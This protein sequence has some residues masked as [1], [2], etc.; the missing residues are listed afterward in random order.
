MSK[1]QRR[2]LREGCTWVPSDLTKKKVSNTPRRVYLG[3]LWSDK[4]K[5]SERCEKTHGRFYLNAL[6]SRHVINRWVDT[7]RKRVSERALPGSP[8]VSTLRRLVI[9]VITARKKL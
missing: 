3:A 1:T 8:S 7:T 5:L 6:R 4:G 9:I 2:S